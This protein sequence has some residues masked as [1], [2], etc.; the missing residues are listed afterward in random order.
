[1]TPLRYRGAMKPTL[2]VA[3]LLFDQVNAL[4]VAGPMEA[5]TSVVHENGDKAYSIV[6]WSIGET[7]VQSETGFR[8]CADRFVPKRPRADILI[9]PGGQGVRDPHN[10]RRLSQWLKENHRHFGRIASVCTGTYVLAEAGLIDGRSVTTHW[11]FARDLQARYPNINVN[12]DALFL[13]DGRYYSS[14]GITAGIDL[15]LDII[16]SDFGAAAAMDAARMMVVFLRRSG[17]Q[18][19]FSMPLKMQTA[20]PGGLDDVCTWAANNLD[21]DL[22]VENLAARAGLSTR[23]F[24]R[25]FR[26][27]YGAPPASYIKRLRLDSGKAMLGQNLTVAQVAHA[28]GYDTADGFTRAFEGQFGV[29]PVEYQ[30]RFTV[31]ESA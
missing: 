30:R 29:T 16:E 15:A 20:A 6:T 21:G 5:F 25:R 10:L 28:L 22:S 11:A 17:A 12:A 4:D 26:E 1:M 31:Q 9:V 3:G 19:Q 13:R 14:G 27:A 7:L 23:Q 18:A 2:K 8:L 24:S